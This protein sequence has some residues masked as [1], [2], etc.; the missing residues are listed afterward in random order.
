MSVIHENTFIE[1][2]RK[3]VEIIPSI[4]GTFIELKLDYFMISHY[5]NSMAIHSPNFVRLKFLNSV[6]RSRDFFVFEKNKY[7]RY[8]LYSNNVIYLQT[9]NS[10]V[11]IL[12]YIVECSLDGRNWSLQ[13]S[14]NLHLQFYIVVREQL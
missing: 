5:D 6:S 1:C 14:R 10:P 8:D 3:Q 4:P 11:S 9:N 13:F 12:E 7:N 2:S